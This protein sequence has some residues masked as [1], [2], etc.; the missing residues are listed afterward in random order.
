LILEDIRPGDILDI[1]YSLRG[2]APG[3][4]G[5]GDEITLQASEP[6]ERLSTRLVWPANRRLF[7]KNHGTTANPVVV[8]RG[9]FQEYKWDLNKV[10]GLPSEGSL[11]I[12]YK[13]HPWVQLSELQNWAQVNQ[14][15]MRLFQVTNS[16]TPVLMER[17]AEWKK[18]ATPEAR[19]LAAVEFVQDEVR[20]QGMEV[21]ASS[22]TACDP[23]TV[24]GRRF[25][26]CKDKALLLVTIL[27]ALQIDAAPVL[28]NTHAR[29]TLD[30]WQPSTFAF[31]HAIVQFVINGET[32]WIDATASFQRGPLSARHLPNYERGLVLRPKTTALSFI[33]M[34]AAESTRNV[35]EQF[36]LQWLDQPSDLKVVTVATGRE[37]DQLRY[38]LATVPRPQ[39]EKA[40]LNYYTKR[41]TDISQTAP[42]TISDNEEQ[43]RLEIT[44]SY[45]IPHIWQRSSADYPYHCEFAPTNIREDISTPAMTL[46]SMPLAVHFPA[47]ETFRIEAT[48]PNNWFIPNDEKTVEDE[49]FRF[50]RTVTLSPRKVVLQ[51]DYK[52]SADSVSPE[53]M[54]QYVRHLDDAQRELAYWLTPP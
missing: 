42:I 44:E 24:F 15:A 34:S 50:H 11:P 17:I 2:D 25:G 38:E 12:W 33:P 20:Y 54:S 48:L 47:N 52:A 9:A 5:F 8:R 13:P 53:R 23:S 49:A 4:G 1:A 37:A 7:I 46:R 6:V 43:N 22:F 19:A 3:F 40:Y 18:L 36:Q 28:I 39:V 41:Y 30:D 10:P 32:F 45:S 29:H 14:L 35:T 26:D 31:N 16:L 21:G 27:R 51:Y